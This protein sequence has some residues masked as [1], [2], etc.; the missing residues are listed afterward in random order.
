[1]KNAVS[2]PDLG[3]QCSIVRAGQVVQSSSEKNL[4]YNNGLLG[5]LKTVMTMDIDQ[6][7]K[8]AEN[9]YIQ[10]ICHDVVN[11]IR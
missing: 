9:P 10:A 7:R 3:Y 4:T 11:Q 6:I 2:R 5:N 1:M 8:E